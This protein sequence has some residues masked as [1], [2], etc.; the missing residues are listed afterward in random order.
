MLAADEPRVLCII[1]NANN[2]RDRKVINSP[3]STTCSQFIADVGKEYG[4]P[5]DAFD[6][7]YELPISSSDEPRQV[8]F[9]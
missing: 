5:A 4:L 9:N 3:I 2:T 1:N 7:V 6:L 8:L